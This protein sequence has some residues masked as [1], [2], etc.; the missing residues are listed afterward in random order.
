M[1][2]KRAL[3]FLL[4]IEFLVGGT[5]L[6]FSQTTW[7]YS[8]NVSG[9]IAFEIGKPIELSN[10][11]FY[12]QRFAVPSSPINLQKFIVRDLNNNGQLIKVLHSDSLPTVNPYHLLSACLIEDTVA[13]PNKLVLIT[14]EIKAGN[15]VYKRYIIDLQFNIEG[16]DSIQCIG[17][18]DHSYFFISEGMTIANGEY[19][20]GGS[21]FVNQPESA[22]LLLNFDMV[23][24]SFKAYDRFE[25][26]GYVLFSPFLFM[27]NGSE[28][29]GFNGVI[30]E[31][32]RLMVDKQLSMNTSLR[33]DFY[34]NSPSNFI[35]TQ[36]TVTD[37]NTVLSVGFF[38]NFTFSDTGR[39][40]LV[41]QTSAGAF[42]DSVSIPS[43]INKWYDRG[44]LDSYDGNNLYLGGSQLTTQSPSFYSGTIDLHKLNAQFQRK[45]SIS[46]GTKSGYA[47]AQM[48]ATSDGGVLMANRF[49]DNGQ[50]FHEIVKIDSL[51]NTVSIVEFDRPNTPFTLYPNPAGERVFV[52]MEAPNEGSMRYSLQSTSGQLIQSE[53]YHPEEGIDLSTLASGVYHLMLWKNGQPIGT[54]RLVVE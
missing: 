37:S 6:S 35:S 26:G 27:H 41:H 43:S 4:V 13:F 3:T 53:A 45:W 44:M 14:S 47:I 10:K 2:Q 42:I 17:C 30:Q 46:L 1:A 19:F 52:Q 51:G 5:L 12:L 34:L 23:S 24:L 15:S 7:R 39:L 28:V 22:V 36:T 11:F 32:G 9:N 16:L 20:I 33:T 48:I 21:F 18:T 50:Y 29:L 25:Y 8:Y 54:E 49:F 40:G 38:R 31:Q